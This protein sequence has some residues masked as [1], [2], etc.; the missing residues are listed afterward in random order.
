MAKRKWNKFKEIQITMTFT[1][2][3]LDY[4]SQKFDIEDKQDLL[5]IVWECI[6]T[7]M[8]M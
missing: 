3:D 6:S 7:Y 2:E 5:D 8:E 1:E 4:L